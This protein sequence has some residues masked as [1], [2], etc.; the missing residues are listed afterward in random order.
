MTTVA[1]FVYLA[2]VLQH[3]SMVLVVTSIFLSG[4]FVVKTW[5]AYLTSD[6]QKPIAFASNWCIIGAFAA[7]F[8][9]S[10]IPE[11]QTMYIMAGAQLADTVA[12]TVM[13]SEYADKLKTIV[14]A[15][16]YEM[17]TNMSSKKEKN[18]SK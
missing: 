5:L 2:D 6:D 4:W 1:I 12:E 17:A 14:D 9:A 7:F 10:M 3:I 8:V 18:E 15:Q 16:L 11:K 13:N